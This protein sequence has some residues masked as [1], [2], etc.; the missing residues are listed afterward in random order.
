MYKARATWSK[1]RFDSRKDLYSIDESP[2]VCC[3]GT[4]TVLK[5]L[6]FEQARTN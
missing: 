4:Q 2:F 3:S 1:R 6:Q 5:S